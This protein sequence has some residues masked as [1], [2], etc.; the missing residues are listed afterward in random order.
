MPCEEKKTKCSEN[1]RIGEKMI[2][3]ILF[4]M[5]IPTA[6]KKLNVSATLG[7]Q[8]LCCWRLAPSEV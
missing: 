7:P 4:A 8:N 3:T 1:Y 6:T 2:Q 5:M